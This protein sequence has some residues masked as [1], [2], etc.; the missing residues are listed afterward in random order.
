MSRSS[1]E[2]DSPRRNR[3]TAIPR[4]RNRNRTAR[5][6]RRSPPLREH[7]RRLPPRQLGVCLFDLRVPARHRHRC[8]DSLVRVVEERDA[9]DRRDVREAQSS[10]SSNAETS[11]STCSG[12]RQGSASTCSSRAMSEST[13]PVLTPRTHRRGG[14]S[15][16]RGSAGRAGLHEGRCARSCRGSDP[17]RTPPG[18]TG[19]RSSGP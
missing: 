13:P 5:P 10:P 14:R 17:A 19:A 4:R 7:P 12:P 18:S 6:L 11:T 2:A 3:R 8:D 1:V 15:R 16:S 9:L